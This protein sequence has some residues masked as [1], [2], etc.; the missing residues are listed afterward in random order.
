MTRL[1]AQAD[2]LRDRKTFL[3]THLTRGFRLV[4]YRASADSTVSAKRKY[5]AG[6]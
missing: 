6:T 1:A 4:T 3:C 5:T 2:D